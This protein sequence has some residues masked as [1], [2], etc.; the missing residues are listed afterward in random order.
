MIDDNLRIKLLVEAVL[1]CQKV[2]KMGMP[3]SCYAKAL[4]EPVHFLWEKRSG[5]KIQAAKYRSKKA[6]NLKFGDGNLIYDHAIP[7]CI[8]QKKLLDLQSVSND[9]VLSVL[10]KHDTICLITKEED[11]I[12]NTAGYKSSMPI[13]WEN[14][15][16]DSL[17]RYKAVG[18]ELI[19]NTLYIPHAE[20]FFVGE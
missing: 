19:D 9:T 4:R 3:S 20:M 10:K 8:L 12:L 5:S 1:Y 13:L 6:V 16:H 14:Q 15:G 11:A 7:F 18:I 17:A 2:Q